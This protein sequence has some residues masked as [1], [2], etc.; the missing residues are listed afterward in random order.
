MKLSTPSID[1][2][3]VSQKDIQ[4]LFTNIT[5]QYDLLNSLL[6]FRIDDYWRSVAVRLG[7]EGSPRSILDIGT[8]TGK[9]LAEFL[10]RRSLDYVVGVDLCESMLVKAEINLESASKMLTCADALALPLKNEAIDLAVSSF[11]LRSL[12]DLSQFLRELARV[13][14]PNGRIVLLELTRPQSWWMR[15]AYY[16]YLNFYL[17]FLGWVISGDRNAYRFLAQSIASFKSRQDVLSLIEAN[18]FTN[19]RAVNL[20]CGLATIFVAQKK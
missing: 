8:G 15:A 2:Q 3:A 1:P 9:L 7:L 12:P 5:P 16:P 4:T 13:L 20:S 14:T 17:P 10:K 11:T 6:S 18:G 19:A